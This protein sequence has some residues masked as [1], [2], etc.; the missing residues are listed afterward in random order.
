MRRGNREDEVVR[1]KIVA[2]ESKATQQTA[3]RAPRNLMEYLIDVHDVAM[4][5]GC[6]IREWRLTHDQIKALQD[7]SGG[8]VRPWPPGDPR[9]RFDGIPIRIVGQGNFA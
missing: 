3:A 1:P 8:L 4:A 5:A 2:A 6:R 9:L 7:E